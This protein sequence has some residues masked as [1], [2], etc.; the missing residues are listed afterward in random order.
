MQTANPLVIVNHIVID[1]TACTGDVTIPADVTFIESSAFY[2][3]TG[4]TS[5]VIPE[6]VPAIGD[7]TFDCCDNLAAVTLPE[8]ITYIG[9]H[10]FDF[11][12]KLKEVT[13]PA[14]TKSIDYAAFRGCRNLSAFTILNPDCEIWDENTTICNHNEGEGP[15][16]TGK[17]RGYDSSTAE[18]YAKKYGCAFESLGAAP[19]PAVSL[20]GDLDL[21]G[22]VDV[23]DAVI[24]AR[25]L[26][27][28][29][30]FAVSDQGLANADA[31]GSGKLTTEDVTYII[32]M[33]VG[34]I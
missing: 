27:G 2:R 8:S 6:G 34:L 26:V 3:A 18:A 28:D 9:E 1:G 32:K 16:F 13:V 20:R 30:S 15:F 11:C 19:L 25:Y 12:D 14:S 17:L 29:D 22:M 33:I 31:D 7:H 4:L 23:S 24:L 10:A 5:I 21:S